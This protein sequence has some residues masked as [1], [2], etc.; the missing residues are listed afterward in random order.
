[1]AKHTHRWA[2]PM[3]EGATVMGTCKCGA[4]KEFATSH[5]DARARTKAAQRGTFNDIAG[6][7]MTKEEAVKARQARAEQG[8][9]ERYA[10]ADSDSV[11]RIN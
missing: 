8:E 9:R 11:R 4:T 5:F 1:M 7:R 3:S 6:V 10:V 2:L